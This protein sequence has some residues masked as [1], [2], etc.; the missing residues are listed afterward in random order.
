MVLDAQR[1][2]LSGQ[3][4][5]GGANCPGQLL[6]AVSCCERLDD[7]HTLLLAAAKGGDCLANFS[8]EHVAQLGEIAGC[9]Y[10]CLLLVRQTRGIERRNIGVAKH[11]NECQRRVG[12]VH[13]GVNG[14]DSPAVRAAGKVLVDSPGG[15]RGL[16]VR[17]GRL[18]AK[19][20]RRSTLRHVVPYL[21]GLSRQ[22]VHAQVWHLSG[23]LVDLVYL[24]HGGRRE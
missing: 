24:L 18:T 6:W 7:L 15:R 16:A 20:F 17:N 13:C 14:P 9:G 10:A 22:P 11:R 2:G 19:T 8:Y 5:L 12:V 21:R 3:D 1:V 4:A 23:G